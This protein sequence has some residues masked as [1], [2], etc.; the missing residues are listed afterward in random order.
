MLS[1]AER[2]ILQ[3]TIDLQGKT[4]DAMIASLKMAG[5]AVESA[6]GTLKGCHQRLDKQSDALAQA[7][8]AMEIA[9]AYIKDNDAGDAAH[10]AGWASDEARDA[11][12]KLR[13]AISAVIVADI[14]DQSEAPRTVQ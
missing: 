5:A 4:I 6:I 12:A 13:A 7:V 2:Q 11:W 1:E 9:A 10:E 3:R 14:D 8:T